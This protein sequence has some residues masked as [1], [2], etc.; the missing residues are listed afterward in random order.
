M[1]ATRTPPRAKARA[2]I[3]VFSWRTPSMGIGCCPPS[4]TEDITKYTQNELRA[5]PTLAKDFRTEKTAK[6][7]GIIS[8][9]SRTRFKNNIISARAS[10]IARWS[11]VPPGQ[12]A[13]VLDQSIR[14]W[15][16]EFWPLGE[17]V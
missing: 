7:G 5:C 3:C 17:N 1:P 8:S 10:G 6:L 4:G 16:G 9:S 11:H 2:E 14:F 13:M 12:S 15:R